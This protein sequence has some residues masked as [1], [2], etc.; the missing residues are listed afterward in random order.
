M[1]NEKNT[2]LNSY[3]QQQQ[4]ST[5][6][7]IVD[8]ITLEEFK[9]FVKKWL[10]VDAY[11]KKAQDLVKEKKK[12]RNKIAEVITKFMSKY[13]IEDLNTKEG[14]IRCKTTYIKASVTQKEMKEKITKLIPERSDIV[15][16]IYEDRPKKEKVSLRR[17]KIS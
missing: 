15:Q 14:R 12:Q 13:N 10:E 3:L 16:K 1:E 17:L 11:I 6:L 5:T 4:S 2:R 7:A 8:E 9:N